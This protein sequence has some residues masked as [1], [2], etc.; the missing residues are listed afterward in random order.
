MKRTLIAA[1]VAGFAALPAYADGHATG[2]ADAGKKVFNKCKSCHTIA[3]P[4]GD[5]I[6]KGGKTG[7]NLF[8]LPGRAAGAADFKR[9]KK[10]LVAAGEAGL[11]WDEEQFVAYVAD[12][13]KYLKAYLDDSKARS[14]MTFKLKKE[15]DA[16]NVW[17]F[18]ASVSPAPMM[19]DGEGGDGS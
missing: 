3:D 8:G 13:T 16:A 11:A 12:P 15:E 18:I 17:A 7:P 5:V 10:S 9:Y 4:E 19:K 14:G 6:L 1:F 2:D